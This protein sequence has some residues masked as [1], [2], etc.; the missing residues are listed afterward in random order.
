MTREPVRVW[1]RK[2]SAVWGAARACWSGRPVVHVE[3]GF[4][5][6]VRTGPEG[7]PA[8][9]H[10]IDHR[11]IYYDATRASDLEVMIE[12]GEA[13]SAELL[14][15]AEAGIAVLRQR[16]LSKYNA[17][18]WRRP[19]DF[20]LAPGGEQ[21]LI[22]DQTAGDLSIRYG[23]ADGST[24]R[25]M[26]D[27]ARR[28]NPDATL[29]VKTHP[30]VTVGKRRGHFGDLED[31]PG[32]RV[33]RDAVNPWALLECCHT[34]YCVTSQLGFEALMAGARVH[35]FGMPFYA[36]WG[37]T[38]DR[39]TCARRSRRVRLEEV[40][41]AAYLL[42]SRYRDPHG[43]APCSFEAVVDHLTRLRDA[44]QAQTEATVC[45]GVDRW[46]RAWTRRALTPAAGRPPRF[47]AP[48]PARAAKWLHETDRVVGWA[49][50]TPPEFAEACRARG[51]PFFWMEDGYL[52]S[53]GLGSRLVLGCSYVL[54]SQRPPFD[55]HGPSDLEDL[56]ASHPFPPALRERGRAFRQRLIRARLTKYGVGRGGAVE[57]LRRAAGRREVVLVAGQVEDDASIRLGTLDVHDNLTLL[58]RARARHAHAYLVFKP[59]PDVVGGLRRGH[60]PRATAERFADLVLAADVA[61]ADVLDAVDR[62]E[63]MTSLL[64]FEALLRGLPVACHGLPFY[65]G[66]GLTEDLAPCPRRGRPLDVDELVAGALLLYP[67]YVDPRSGRPCTPEW[68]LEHL[69]RTPAA[70]VR[71]PEALA[72]AA[73]AAVTR[74][75]RRLSG[76]ASGGS[77]R[78]DPV[79]G[80]D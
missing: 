31:G 46:K 76:A 45:V 42:Y 24:F 62:V 37:L 60:V 29:V 78:P 49:S 4:L 23:R 25:R 73:A 50:R 20:G 21:V 22:V 15:R 70:P 3:D 61:A 8:L 58:S 47:R 54:D 75:W 51:V 18:P 38:E 19:E 71:R 67:H 5:R 6:S 53:A 1:G 44:A 11:G 34:L 69:P 57:R 9:S 14:A 74:R 40:F 77:V 56:L 55:A 68:L 80:A 30:A 28:E 41:A 12:S 66:W 79:A 16:R 10:V 7:E 26:L 64:G 43:L 48:D 36:G 32:L 13:A 17:A 33:V 59:H 65:A 39:L 35:C 72:V 63:V 27:A 52:R 2:P